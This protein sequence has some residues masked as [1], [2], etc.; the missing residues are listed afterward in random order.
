MWRK[1]MKNRYFNRNLI[2]SIFF[3]FLFIVTIIL[4]ETDTFR[5]FDSVEV[6]IATERIER[7]EI[8]DASKVTLFSFP[9]ELFHKGMIVNVE[10]IVGKRAVHPIESNSFITNYYLDDSILKPTPEHEFFPIPPEWMLEIQGTLRRYDLVNISAVYVGEN[11]EDTT[12]VAKVRRDYVFK[13]VPVAY[14]KGNKNQEVSNIKG[15]PDRLYG[16]TN[17]STVELSLTIEQFKQLE[18]LYHEG[19]R[20]VF[21]Y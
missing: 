17:P 4:S 13:D 11:K 8:I 3:F 2:I 1:Q 6:V 15:T 12:Q 7:N 16:T 14:V 9:R 19:Y 20:F 5:K 10:D 18:S 21:S